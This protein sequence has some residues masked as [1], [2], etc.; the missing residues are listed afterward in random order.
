MLPTVTRVA[1]VRQPLLLVVNVV[2]NV[3]GVRVLQV[4][5]NVF[6]IEN[7]VYGVERQLEP[8][9]DLLTCVVYEL[10]VSWQSVLV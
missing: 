9:L 8:V 1:N 10:V 2:K 6:V 7:Y 4:R 3:L 5:P